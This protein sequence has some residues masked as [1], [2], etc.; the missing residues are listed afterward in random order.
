MIRHLLIL[1]VLLLPVSLPAQEANGVTPEWTER[2]L[3]AI[4][5]KL[6]EG[7]AADHVMSFYYF[8]T[9]G[10]L[11]LM[12]LERVQG[13]DY[14]QFFSLMIFNGQTLEGYYQNV[15]SFPSGVTAAG[16]VLFPRDVI[17][18]MADGSPFNITDTRAL[19]LCQTL[20]DQQRCFNWVPAVQ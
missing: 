9:H 18:A 11:T 16:D 14:E 20:G 1:M 13:D 4:Q 17:S 12:G 2:Y 3:K 15:F 7:A 6:L 5:S 10:T 19:A 8:G